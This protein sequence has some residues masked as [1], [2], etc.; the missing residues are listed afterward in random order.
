MSGI[1]S[2]V[3]VRWRWRW[4]VRP[5]VLLALGLVLVMAGAG[6]ST[7]NTSEPR[8][9]DEVA[10][11]ALAF[12]T[13]MTG[14]PSLAGRAIEPGALRLEGRIIDPEDQAIGGARVTLGDGRVVQSEVDGSFAF[15]GLAEG[16]YDVT[17]EHGD[18][19]AE[20]QDVRLDE[21]SEPVMVTLVRG[22]TL[23]LHVTDPHGRP[24]AGATVE[25]TPRTF[26]TGTDG[27]ARIRGV[28][29][30]DEYV[31]VSAA[32]RAGV[33]ERVTTSDDPAATIDWTIVLAAGAEVA[34]TVIDPDGRP[35]PDAYVELEQANGARRDAVFADDTGAWRTPAPAR[36][37]CARARSCTSRRRT[38]RSR[39]MARIP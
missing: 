26:V 10:G 3:R 33:R 32:G 9:R 34:G 2:M 36:T 8:D 27:T 11:R 7:S 23:V 15:D 24:I 14:A 21:T 38:S 4:L 20:V 35:V 13:V 31:V 6:H 1:E 17:A 18:Q 37:P 30:D 12:P 19:Y 28:A 39:T 16:R 25:L 22:P 5:A 29:I